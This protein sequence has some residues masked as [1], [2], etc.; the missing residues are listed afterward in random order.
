LAIAMAFVFLV[1][2]LP[3]SAWTAYGVF[4]AALLLIA[5]FS[6]I[7]PLQLGRRLL[8]VEPFAVGVAVL[9]LLQKGG[10]HIFAAMLARSTLCLFCMVLLSSTT[11]FSEILRV[12]RVI[13]VPGL[14]VTTLAL[15]HR[16]LFVL[17]DEMM[18][19]LRARKSRTFR[20]SRLGLWWDL[21]GAI[22]QLFIRS[23]ERAER[24]YAAMSARGW[25][26]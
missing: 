13:R 23:S 12:L 16:Y 25:R 24:I 19:M 15:T 6:R 7:P 2:L 17:V 20:R 3:R 5:A 14:L 18:R 8:L 22:A 4:A 11:R 10:L 21:A 26:T 1:V 9:S